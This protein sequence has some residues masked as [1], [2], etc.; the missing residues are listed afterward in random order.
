MSGMPFQL[1]KIRQATSLD[2][3]EYFESTE[4]TNTSALQRIKADSTVDNVLVLTEQQKAGRGRGN[5]RWHADSG[6]LTFSLIKYFP[7]LRGNALASLGLVTGIAVAEA[8]EP[9]LP[10]SVQLKWPNDIFLHRKKLGGILIETTQ[11]SPQTLVIGIGINVNNSLANAPFDV[12]SKSISITDVTDT[13]IPLTDV[14]IEILQQ[15]ENF[16]GQVI[17]NTADIPSLWN[18]RCML[19]GSE[20]DFVQGDVRFQGHCHGVQVDGALLLE[21]ESE[22]RPFYSGSAVI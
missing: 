1:T 10:Q 16:Y 6:A 21:I 12:A 9:W 4:S 17:A 8:L 19:N 18:P 5:H 7:E 3:I 13:D 20:V 14:L 2:S 11:E 22:I 15:L